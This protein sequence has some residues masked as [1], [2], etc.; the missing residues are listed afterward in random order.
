MNK[1]TKIKIC[2][3]KRT[4]DIRIVNHYLPDYCGFIV[5]FP[6]SHRSLTIEEVKNLAVKVDRTHIKVVGVFVNEPLSHVAELLNDG[7]LDLAQLHGNETE[8]YIK[9]LKN[10]TEKKIIKAFAVKDAQSLKTANK[11]SA[12][13]ILLDQGQGSG[14]TFD[15]SI[16]KDEKA[17]HL[18]ESFGVL[19]RECFLAGGLNAE[20]IEEAIRE[21]HP[22]AVDLS[23]AVETDRVKDEK[24]IREII[25]IVRKCRY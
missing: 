25:E 9:E 5:N 22:Y 2:G 19:T 7:T 6:K 12:D 3:L 14:M 21:F 17:I 10:L 16:L 24:K 1:T 23:S 18:K 20:N 11:S 4:E 13:Y 8:Q 15:W